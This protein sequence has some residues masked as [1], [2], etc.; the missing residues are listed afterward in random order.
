MSIQRW[1]YIDINQ[2]L[3]DEGDRE[4]AIRAVPPDRVLREDFGR[5]VVADFSDEVGEC[6]AGMF[7]LRIV[8]DA[9]AREDWSTRY[10]SLDEGNTEKW[11]RFRDAV[12]D[13]ITKYAKGSSLHRL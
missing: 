10:K 7:P 4:E 9:N 11:R 5:R 12:L 13:S 6:Q 2:A 1:Y 3:A 8:F